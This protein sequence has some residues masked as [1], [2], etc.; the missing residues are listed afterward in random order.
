MNQELIN[1]IK[2]SINEKIDLKRNFSDH[3]INDLVVRTVLDKSKEVFLNTSDKKQIIETVFNS[4]RRLDILQPILDD[5]QVTE[6]MIN[7]PENIFVEKKGKISHLEISFESQQKLED[8][9][10]IMVTAV[11]RTVNESNPIVDARLKDGSRL[12]VVLPPIALNGPIVTI[13]KFPGK[14]ID[15]ESLIELQSLTIEAAEALKMLVRAKYNIFVAGSTGSGKTTYLNALSNFIPTDERIITIED[16]AEL[17]IAN[18]SN[19]VSL[20]TR[21]ANVEG[22]GEITIRKLIKTALRMRPNRIIVG[23]VRGEEAIDMLSAMNTGHDGSLSTGHANSTQDMFSRLETMILSAANLPLEAVR[24]QI[25]SAIDIIIFLS[26]LR[27]GSRRTI[28]ISEVLG[29]ENGL[30]KL[31]P[32]FIFEE[33]IQTNHK[34]NNTVSGSLKR[35]MNPLINKQKMINSGIYDDF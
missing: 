27:D 33:D 16:S 32:L 29:I 6:I 25:A 17:Q 22:R 14:P 2:A 7:G 34:A 10:Q 15:M 24:K 35:T 8:I 19:L 31:N 9:I 23:E 30:I 1:E 28:D 11:N 3:E 20:E 5:N 13:R 12:N 26:R 4:L 21:N 18:I